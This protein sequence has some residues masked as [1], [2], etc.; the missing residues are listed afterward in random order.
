VI[1]KNTGEYVA[2]L[3]SPISWSTEHPKVPITVIPDNNDVGILS[4]DPNF[5]IELGGF[6]IQNTGRGY[7]VPTINIIDKDT[8]LKNGEVEAVVVDGRIVDLKIK[9]SGTNFKRI[10]R[11]EIIDNGKSKLLTELESELR[12]RGLSSNIRQKGDKPK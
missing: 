11:I 5:D 1:D 2:L 6:Y 3:T 8:G 9:N 4:Q 7:K 12:R 10:P